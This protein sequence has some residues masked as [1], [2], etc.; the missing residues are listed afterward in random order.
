MSVVRHARPEAAIPAQ[1]GVRRTSARARG[2]N[3]ASH[4]CTPCSSSSREVSRR[5][6][7]T[8]VESRPAATASS[9]TRPRA[10][11]P[12]QYLVTDRAGVRR[13]QGCADP[14]C[15]QAG[16]RVAGD[17]LP[18]ARRARTSYCLRYR[19]PVPGGSTSGARDVCGP[20][21]STLSRRDDRRSMRRDRAS[22]LPG[23]S[24]R[25]RGVLSGPEDD[26]V[27]AEVD[28]LGHGVCGCA[29][30]AA[31]CQVTRDS[32]IS[33]SPSRTTSWSSTTSTRVAVSRIA[34][35]L[36]APATLGT[37]GAPCRD[38]GPGDPV[39]LPTLK[40]VAGTPGPAR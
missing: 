15:E 25:S 31:H 7:S 16:L 11:H 35:C 27:G 12:V 10:G 14:Q 26:D 37:A 28:R 34:L 23:G 5:A 1:R 17:L 40:A 32:R 36:R 20:R 22:P 29:G 38:E 4:R 9:S 2:D 8:V 13:V 33:R 18:G 30:L 19:Q 6:A 21:S 3:A 39:A 24:A